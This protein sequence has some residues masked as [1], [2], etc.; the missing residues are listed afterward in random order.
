MKLIQQ[1][2]VKR[3][4]NKC[5]ELTGIA[6]DIGGT[7]ARIYEFFEGA[8]R[9]SEQIELSEPL[10]EEDRLQ[11]GRERVERITA[12][13]QDF[14]GAESPA[15]IPVACAG[16]KNAARDEVTI[17]TF[18]TPLPSLC[19]VIRERL[20]IETEPLYDDD[21]AAGWG[22]IVSG[23]SELCS[24]VNTALLTA[25]T[26]L[27][28]FLTI[29]GEVVPKGSYPRASEFGLEE[30]LRAEGWRKT[31]CP[32]E[33]LKTWLKIR[34]EDFDIQRLLLSGRFTHLS[35]EV[36]ERLGRELGLPVKAVHLD[37]APALGALAM[38]SFKVL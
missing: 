16:G 29:N 12:M 35:E 20:N 13:I 22:H 21:V 14:C 26:G 9:R 1:S 3:Y 28:E 37:W 8:P 34:R 27:A 24:T 6:V 11:L 36:L 32:T 4:A 19:R 18:A 15:E 38:K 30:A 25:G 7:R 17:S 10:P 5:R 31:G 2:G 23:R 33:A